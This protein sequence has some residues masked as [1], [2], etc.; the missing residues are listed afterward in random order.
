MSDNILAFIKRIAPVVAAD[1]SLDPDSFGDAMTQICRQAQEEFGGDRV[2]VPSLNNKT[3]RD[4]AIV[5][6]WR[7]G[8][9]R[10]DIAKEHGVSR[11]TV[12]LV[13]STALRRRQPS[14]FGSD[15]WA[16]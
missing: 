6:A 14:G 7:K 5:A 2:Y 11:K 4:R 10:L 13:I 3:E 12:D 9:K 16:L 1:Y 8:K 15:E